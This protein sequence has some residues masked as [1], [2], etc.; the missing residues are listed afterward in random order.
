MRLTE[1]TAGITI[2]YI[3]L[4]CYLYISLSSIYLSLS[5]GINSYIFPHLLSFS[6]FLSPDEVA[7]GPEDLHAAIP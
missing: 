6:R 7:V 5:L 2:L 4:S 3:L 1:V